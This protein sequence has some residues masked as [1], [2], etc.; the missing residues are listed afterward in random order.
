MTGIRLRYLT[1]TG[2]NIEPAELL[3]DD[4]LNIIYGASNTGKSFASKAI[5]FMLGVSK[6][7]PETEE[8]AAYDAAWL[9]LTLPDERDITLYRATRGGAFKLYE[10]HVSAAEANG[11][12]VLR[13]RHDSARTDSV[14]HLLLNAMG[15]ASKRIVRDANGKKD[16]LSIYLLSPYAV[17]SEEDIIAEKSPVFASGTPSERTFE[18]NLFKLLITGIDDSAAVTVPKYS[19]RKA[20]KV[21]KIELVD[22][23]IEQINGELG[24]NPPGETET[25]SQ[26][27]R[28]DESANGLSVRLRDAQ[29]ELDSLIAERRDATDRRRELQ[30]R[31]AE[32]EL[33]LQRFAKLQA[34]Y[35][36][37]LERLQSIEEGG[38]VLVAL[39][40]MDCPVCGAAPSAQKHNHAADEI[41]I[42]HMAAAAEARKIEREQQELDQ[43]IMS[44]QEQA[45]ELKRTIAQIS[46]DAERLD[47]H[48]QERRPQEASLRGSYEAY[49]AKRIQIIKV[50]DLYERR[51]M[52][53]ARRAAIDA[54]PTKRDGAAPPVGPDS[55]TAYRFGETLKGVLTAW[56]FPNADKV[57]FDE[58]LNDITVAGKRRAA[59]GKGVRA[60]L[61][62]AFNVAVIVYCVENKLPHPGFLVLDTPLLTYREP[63]TSRH[64][65]LS[66]DEAVLKATNLAEHFYK[67]LAGLKGEV[68]FIVIENSDPPSSIRDLARI[69]TFTGREGNGRFGLL[70]RSV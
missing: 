29:S 55:S 25:K 16:T 41:S 40:G 69:E 4:G 30:E 6:G 23:L 22:E 57:K 68:Q 60:I 27:D 47:K 18:Q 3:F 67:H 21:A 56:H 61:H 44:L 52:L 54:E 53:V 58:K 50:L 63:L 46:V 24:E 38:Y 31:S 59:N 66:E 49:S 65:D 13:E 2:P 39:A 26:L 45:A 32:L 19:E 34:V 36:S 37:D 15:F 48:I 1:F 14:S 7:L 33:T 9:C 12:V 35:R 70:A 62:A 20:A 8:I 64:G 42:A 11:G 10:G 28:L 17:V 5:L 43:T 51:A